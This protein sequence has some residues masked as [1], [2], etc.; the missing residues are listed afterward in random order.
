MVQQCLLLYT[1][2]KL[3]RLGWKFHGVDTLGMNPVTVPSSAWYG[4]IPVPRMVQNQLNHRLELQMMKLDEE[5]RKGLAKLRGREVWMVATCA[6]FILLH[7]RELDAARN[8][9][10]KQYQD[11]VSYIIILG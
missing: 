4:V 8:V 3:L 1:A 5:I 9:F 2:L 11:T 10:W 7:I 6:T